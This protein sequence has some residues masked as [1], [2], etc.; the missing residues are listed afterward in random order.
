MQ[1]RKHSLR[2]SLVFLLFILALL[3]FSV[4]LILIQAFRSSYLTKLA[5]KQ[6]N[7]FIK[8]EPRRGAIYDRNIRPLAL[9]V[10]SYSVY[11]EPKTMNKDGKEKAVEK[12][13]AF[14]KLDAQAVR[15]K[16][17]RP[18]YFVWIARKL[19]FEQAEEIKKLKLEGIDFIK[20]SRRF[21]PNHFLAAHLIGFA[22]T[23]NEGLEGLELQYD[24]YLKGE[25]GWSQILRDARQ[26]KLLLEKSFIPPK[27]GFDLVLTID[28][29]IQYI[30]ERALDKAFKKHNAKGAMIVVMNPRT[31]EILA[32]ANRPTFN[33]ERPS[34]SRSDQ[35]RNRAI[36]DMYEP[37][38]VFKIVTAADRK[39]VV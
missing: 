14:L 15:E 29:T 26:Q 4:K 24:N 36:A 18:K 34:D 8:L 9:N 7:Y 32:W 6:H 30:A 22:G 33:L 37:G 27:D 23:D 5:D 25:Y 35:R 20:E 28:E 3:I 11:A 39:S 12:L 13:S 38:S 2:F 16:L 19:T 10:A 21:Y 17:N 31:G 1:I